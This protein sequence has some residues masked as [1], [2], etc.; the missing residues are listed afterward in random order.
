MSCPDKKRDQVILLEIERRKKLKNANMPISGEYMNPI[1]LEQ[2]IM[3][4]PEESIKQIL[5]TENGWLIIFMDESQSDATNTTI[6]SR[7]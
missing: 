6:P 1:T 2:I 4:T 3:E 7:T 5:R